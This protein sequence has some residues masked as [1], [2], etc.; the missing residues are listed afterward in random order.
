[1]GALEATAFVLNNKN[2]DFDPYRFTH[3]KTINEFT[4]KEIYKKLKNIDT[5]YVTFTYSLESA[6]NCQ[7]LPPHLIDNDFITV[8]Y[9]SNIRYFTHDYTTEFSDG[10]SL[11]EMMN[12]IYN[13]KQY[14]FFD[15]QCRNYKVEAL[16]KIKKYLDLNYKG[17]SFPLYIDYMLDKYN[18]YKFRL[19]KCQCKLIETYNYSLDEDDELYNH[20]KSNSLKL[21]L[22]NYKNSIKYEIGNMNN[23]INNNL[24]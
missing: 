12:I 16:L 3:I 18:L 11:K 7:K 2:I 5:D 14:H 17:N 1:M 4:L 15:V 10:T 24:H 9:K 13:K 21:L 22:E 20:T 19:I 6:R 23:E 8:G